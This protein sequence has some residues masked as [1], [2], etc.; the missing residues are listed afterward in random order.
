MSDQGFTNIRYRGKPVK[1]D[2]SPAIM[3]SIVMQKNNPDR[4]DM[5]YR[6]NRQF[7]AEQREWAKRIRRQTARGLSGTPKNSSIDTSGH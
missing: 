5:R 3:R 6:T 7:I 2:G 4:L 1:R